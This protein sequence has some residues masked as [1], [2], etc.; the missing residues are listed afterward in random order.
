MKR[1]F[2]QW[3]VGQLANNVNE[4]KD[5]LLLHVDGIEHWLL[6]VVSYVVTD[7]PEGQAMSLTKAGATSSLRNCRVCKKE[8][9]F[10]STT[11]DGA[12]AKAEMESS[13]YMEMNGFWRLNLYSDRYGHHGMFPADFLHTLCHGTADILRNVLLA[14]GKQFDTLSGECTFAPPHS[15][16]IHSLFSH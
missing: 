7:W 16:V 12:V 10:F 8:T 15:P 14:Y 11:S 4:Y 3:V 2:Y 5:G 6:P 13:I 9:K 1:D